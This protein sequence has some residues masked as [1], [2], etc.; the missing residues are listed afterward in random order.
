MALDDGEQFG[1]ESESTVRLIN[2]ALDQTSLIIRQ[3]VA[4]AKAELVQ[5]AKRA[6][7]AGLHADVAEIKEHLR[8]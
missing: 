1:L 3:E 4:P 6:V 2:R 5:K 7:A 8:R